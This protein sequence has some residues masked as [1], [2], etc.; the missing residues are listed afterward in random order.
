MMSGLMDLLGTK[1][2]EEQDER[3]LPANLNP[4]SVVGGQKSQAGPN[5]KVSVKKGGQSKKEEA[6]KKAAIWDDKEFK[7]S[8][9]V[10]AKEAPSDDRQA[11]E[12]EILFRQKLGSQDLF[13]NMGEKDASSDHCE[14]L[15]VK[16]KLPNTKL[17][18]ITLDVLVDRVMLQSPHYKLNAAL[19]YRVQKDE[20][21]AKWDKLKGE[22]SVTLPIDAKIKYFTDVSEL[23]TPAASSETAM[24]RA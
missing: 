7:A 2:H 22:L 17:K 3:S 14:E 5:M 16:V 24:V 12:Y 9:G 10:V 19:P 21:N 4:A 1:R 6:E 8:S 13:L 11:P 18:D 23:M 15:L 20:G